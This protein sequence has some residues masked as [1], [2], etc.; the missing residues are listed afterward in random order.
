MM[1][2]RIIIVLLASIL[3]GATNVQAKPI[4]K[5]NNTRVV[6]KSWWMYF[7]DM[8]DKTKSTRVL[9][10]IRFKVQDENTLIDDDNSDGDGT[11]SS[12]IVNYT[13]KSFSNTTESIFMNGNSHHNGIIKISDQ[14][15]MKICFKGENKMES[16]VLIKVYSQDEKFVRDLVK[17]YDKSPNYRILEEKLKT[18]MAAWDAV[19]EN[20]KAEQ[21]KKNAA[22]SAAF[23]MP[24]PSKFTPVSNKICLEA[25]NAR[26]NKDGN[27]KIAYCYFGSSKHIRLKTQTEWGI[28]KEKKLVSG[29]YDDVI[30]K[31]SL[32]LIVVLQ[33][34][35]K[36]GTDEYSV[37]HATLTE[38]AAYGVYNGSK[39]TGKYYILSSSALGLDIPSKNA[40]KY[41]TGLK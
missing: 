27:C 6:A 11:R 2:K 18:Y 33:Y 25:A 32:D 31:R 12:R 38:D 5:N 28:H 41:K 37:N 22:I 10:N 21:V 3:F 24:L 1:S 9:E 20:D 29:T 8:D 23:E 39:F 14:T 16:L 36:W 17:N 26:F 40:L 35:S 4:L 30:T 15:Y 7:E 34:K 19:Y 13:K